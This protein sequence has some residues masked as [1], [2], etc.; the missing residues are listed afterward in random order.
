MNVNGTLVLLQ[1]QF[2]DSFNLGNFGSLWRTLVVA[3]IFII[4]KISRWSWEPLL[5]EQKLHDCVFPKKSYADTCRYIMVCHLWKFQLSLYNDGFP[6][7]SLTIHTAWSCTAHLNKSMQLSIVYFD[8]QRSKFQG[9]VAASIASEFKLEKSTRL[10]RDFQEGSC[11]LLQ[12]MCNPI[13]SHAIFT[14][15]LWI[16]LSYVLFVSFALASYYADNI[17]I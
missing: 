8:L 16:A 2:I 17:L 15:R 12:I 1:F 9:L 10:S 3:I 7:I 5:N 13:S 6:F 14:F 4:N 11:L